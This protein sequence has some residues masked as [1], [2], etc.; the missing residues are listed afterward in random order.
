MNP[1]SLLVLVWLLIL[2]GIATAQSAEA[3]TIVPEANNASKSKTAV[4][5]EAER[6]IKDRRAQA[7]SMLISLAADAGRFNDQKLRARTL[8]RIADALW[9][10]DA[11]RGRTLFRRAWDAAETADKESQQLQQEEIQQQKAKTGGNVAVS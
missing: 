9:D 11:E 10:T 1:R 8:A 4:D 7:Q 3:K 5:P 6:I 2:G